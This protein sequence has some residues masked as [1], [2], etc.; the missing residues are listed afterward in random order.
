MW[1]ELFCLT[2]TEL[3]MSSARHPETDG[4]TERVNQ[5]LEDFLRCFVSS[6]QTQWAHWVPLAEFWY[7]TTIHS[8]L[9]KTPFEVL[10]GHTLKHFG[11]DVVDSCQIPDLHQW[12]KDRA[13]MQQLLHQ[14]LE[15][16]Q[17]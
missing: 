4:Q 5:C 11:V 3:R 17:Q 9:G 16:Q 2:Q 10:Y 15:R 8:M 13:T 14:H 1:Q 7:N 6:C 12:L